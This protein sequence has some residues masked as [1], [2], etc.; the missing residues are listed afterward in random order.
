M[1]QCGSTV[2]GCDFHGSERHLSP[3]FNS[4]S[5]NDGHIACVVNY[6]CRNKLSLLNFEE[7]TRTTVQ[8]IYRLEHAIHHAQHP[9]LTDALLL[10]IP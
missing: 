10:A 7:M 8:G 1:I 9:S 5:F 3:F 4:P 6:T 2:C